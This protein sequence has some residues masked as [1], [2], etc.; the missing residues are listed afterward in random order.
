VPLHLPIVWSS[1]VDHS[2]EICWIGHEGARWTFEGTATL[3]EGS[4]PFAIDYLL[5]LDRDTGLTQFAGRIRSGSNAERSIIVS[6][7]P[8]TAWGIAGGD[9]GEGSDT[10]ASGTCIDLGWTPLTNTFSIWRLDLA[11]GESADIVNAWVPFPEFVLK[12]AVQRYTRI[13]E[14]RYR[15][16]QPEIDFAADLDV[17]DLGFVWRYEDFWERVSTDDCV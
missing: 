14:R 11:I 5:R 4:V 10:L 3:V 7:S 15:Y 13:G 8:G 12:P 6:G 9:G 16:E 1:L 2:L 17:D